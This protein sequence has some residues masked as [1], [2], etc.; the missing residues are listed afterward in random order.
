MV[1][2]MTGYGRGE[3]AIDGLRLTAEVRTVNHRFCEIATRLPRTLSA[4]EG[5]VRRVLTDRF[6]RGKISL[7]ISWGGEGEEAREPTAT[8]RLDERAAGRYVELLHALKERYRLPGELDIASFSSLPNLFLWE[9]PEADRE[10]HLALLLDVVT[11]ACED[12]IRMK[13]REG[14]MLRADMEARVRGI[15]ERVAGIRERAPGR[16]RE[17]LERMRERMRLLLEEGALPEERLAQEAALLSD[18][19]DCTEECVRLEAHCDH[20]GRLLEEEATP[21]RK[22]NFLLQEM[23]REI[24]TIGS[25]SSDVPIVEQVVDVKEELER[26][27]EQVQNIE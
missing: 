14:E 21:G 23:N 10:H 11:R 17:A 19:L 2:S 5:E 7:T 3:A 16:V 25:K 6:T 26:I 15:R 12:A 1:R 9:E 8:L 22:L 18:R 20:F 27:R 13:E 24:N 4:F